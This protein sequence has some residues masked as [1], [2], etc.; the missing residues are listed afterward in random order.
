MSHRAWTLIEDRE[1]GLLDLR[2]V[3]GAGGV[4]GGVGGSWA[5]EEASVRSELEA[6]R[7][8][9]VGEEEGSW[10]TSRF[11]TFASKAMGLK[12]EKRRRRTEAGMGG[13]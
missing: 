5:L 6:P 8:V 3:D 10:R 13:A 1:D 9:F 2:R 12:A 7:I 11:L 4:V